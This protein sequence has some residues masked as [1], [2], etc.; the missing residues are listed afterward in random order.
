[1][2]E[3]TLRYFWIF[4][5]GICLPSVHVTA[6]NPEP[7]D[8]VCPRFAEGS[9]VQDP[10]E[11]YS[12]RGQ[13]EV[14]LLFKSFVDAQGLRRYCYITD[15]GL[16]APTLHLNPGDRLLINFQNDLPPDSE[17]NAANRDPC[18]GGPMS[19]SSTNLHFHGLNVPPL[20]HQDE[21]VKTLIAPGQNFDYNLQIPSNQPPG[22]YWY[23]PHAH[24]FTE[25]QVQGGAAGAIVVGGI[26]A[27]DKPLARVPQ[28]TFVLRDQ[29][30]PGAKP[31]NTNPADKSRPGWDVSLNYVPVTFPGYTPAVIKTK[32]QEKQFW[33]VLNAAADTIF[34]LQVIVNGK[35]QPLEVIALDGVP[36]A[37][38]AQQNDILLDPGSRAE[39]LITTPNLGDSAQFV[40]Q[41]VD[42]GIAGEN[43]PLR[44]LANIVAENGYSQERTLASAKQK[45]RAVRFVE[46]AN[47][48]KPT[49]ERT[50]YFSELGSEDPRVG[51]RY[52]LTVAGQDREVYR[53]GQAPNVIVHQGAVEDWTIEN[54]AFQD[55]TFHMHQLHFRVLEVNGRPVEDPIS[56]DTIDVPHY[57][58]HGKYPSVKLRLDFRDPNILGTFV[59]H[60]H[61]LQHEDGGMMGAIRLVPP[62]ADA[63]ATVSPSAS[64]VTLYDL[65]DVTASV[66]PTASVGSPAGGA[67]RFTLDKDKIFEVPVKDGVATLKSMMTD[68]GQ[69]IFTALYLGDA[70]YSPAKPVTTSVNVVT[71]Y[72]TLSGSEPIHV[73][74]PEKSASTTFKVNSIGGFNQSVRLN[75]LPPKELAG[76]QC[77][78]DPPSLTGS[79]EATLTFSPESLSAGT[80][81]V[82]VTGVSGKEPAQIKKTL[83][84][85]LILH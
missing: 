18:E 36:L 24:G 78:I 74:P 53:M 23:H 77:S 66:A 27:A 29:P 56:H 72:F 55:H 21:V 61:I 20:C 16:Q 39:F 7:T 11:L 34:D 5:L 59:Y 25:R 14:A 13:L 28:R 17:M 6:Q 44:P 84:V 52:F 76:G 64:T 40:T 57:D 30:L 15:S 49:L 79:G 69:H 3:V 82:T 47:E 4:A 71:S 38:S 62:G 75:C 8:Q 54:H 85:S 22:L 32:P 12:K 83:S 70:T 37:R 41:A 50:L 9:V 67:V 42:T 31:A 19:Q 45:L 10:P 73:R 63:K 43:N 81:N 58:G 26:N 51:I 33:R 1:M 46:S 35:A 60:C 65:V 68:A 80:Y 2:A 48:A